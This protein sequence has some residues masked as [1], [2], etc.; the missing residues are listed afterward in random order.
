MR[1]FTVAAIVSVA[2]AGVGAS[3][4]SAARNPNGT[5]QPSV[6]CVDPGATNEPAGFGTPG[7]ANAE[8]HY[9]SGANGNEGR[10]P[11]RRRLLPSDLPPR[12]L[13]VVR[14]RAGRAGPSP[15]IF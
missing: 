7:F 11:V 5:G 15:T 9:A 1:R 2:I 12:Q 3:G 13:T 4:A 14:R 8:D 10:F 6:E